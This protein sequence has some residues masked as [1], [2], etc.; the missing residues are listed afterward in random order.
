MVQ[1]RFELLRF[2]CSLISPHNFF[3]L[4]VPTVT[5]RLCNSAVLTRHY[6]VLICYSLCTSGRLPRKGAS[7]RLPREVAS[8][9]CLGK[10]A[11]RRLCF[12]IVVFPSQLN[13]CYNDLS[14]CN[15]H[16]DR[17]FIPRHT[18]VAGYYGI[19]LDVRTSVRLSYVR[20]SVFLFPDDN[21]SKC[22]GIFTKLS[23]CIDVVEICFG[24]VNGKIS[25]IFDRVVCP[26]YVRIFISGW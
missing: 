25:S 14:A 19:T 20:L 12:V 3:L 18:I 15:F 4:T 11:L 22:Q 6:L 7:G 17:I 24:M 9:S 1:K 2:D 5:V 26:R 13:P 16:N 21:L 10:A 8:R 23:V